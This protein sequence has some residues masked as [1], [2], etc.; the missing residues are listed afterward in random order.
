METGNK[1]DSQKFNV[2]LLSFLAGIPIAILFRIGS[3][4][5]PTIFY[6]YAIEN[7]QYIVYE[8]LYIFSSS[9]LSFILGYLVSTVLQKK[10]PYNLIF[11]TIPITIPIISF[12]LLFSLMAG[13][14]TNESIP[15]IFWYLPILPFYLLGIFFKH[16]KK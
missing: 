2:L 15:R 12:T 4:I 14:T 13:S 1:I 8:I 9:F 6:S 7:D 16:S 3:G 11:F 10:I 5:L